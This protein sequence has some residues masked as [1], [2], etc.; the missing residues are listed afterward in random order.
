MTDVTPR[1][2]LSATLITLNAATQLAA[3]LDSLAFCDEIVVVDSGSTDE[4]LS[5]ARQRGARVVHCD[6]RGFGRQKQFAVEQAC[7]DW[8]LCV[9]A[10]ERVSEHLRVSLLAALRDPAHTVYRFAR[11]NRFLGRYLRHGEGYPD[12]SLRLFDRRHARWSDDVVHEK[13]LTDVPPATLNGDLL[14]DSAE[15]LETYLTK[16]N[17][18]TTLA[19]QAAAERGK[20]AHAGHLLLSPM[21]RFIRFYIFRRGFLDGLPGLVHILIGCGN[22]FAKYAKLIELQRQRSL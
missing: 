21:L 3:C 6:W 14:H 19:A 4:T 18:Y 12:M 20:R 15:T 11:C 22:S 9:D 17:R 5:I 8:V 16:Q 2:G 13:V 7:H 1:P 10:D